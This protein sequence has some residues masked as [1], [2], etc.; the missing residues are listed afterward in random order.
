M[1]SLM[2]SILVCIMGG[3]YW[4]SVGGGTVCL[5]TYIYDFGAQLVH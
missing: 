5:F 3:W 4:G 1:I 2:Q